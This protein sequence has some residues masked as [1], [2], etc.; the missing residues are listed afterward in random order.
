[1]NHET[2]DAGLQTPVLSWRQTSDVWR[3][4]FQLLFVM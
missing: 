1:M 4:A 2:P 3:L